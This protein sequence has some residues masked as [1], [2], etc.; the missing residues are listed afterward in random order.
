[1]QVGFAGILEQ[2]GQFK[3]NGGILIEQE[4]FEHRLVDRDHLLHVGPGKVH[5]G[6]RIFAGL[7]AAEDF[8]SRC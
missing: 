8:R 2:F 3:T 4:P 6:A 1:L 5:G 7:M